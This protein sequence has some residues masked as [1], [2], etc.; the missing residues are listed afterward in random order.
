ME[1]SPSPEPAGDWSLGKVLMTGIG[2]AF[3]DGIVLAEAFPI[4]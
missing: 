2:V 3:A 1:S 4:H